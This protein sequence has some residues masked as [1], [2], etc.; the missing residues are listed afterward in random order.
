M[1][2][3]IFLVAFSALLGSMVTTVILLQAEKKENATSKVGIVKST[4]G[5]FMIVLGVKKEQAA[6]LCKML[7][8]TSIDYK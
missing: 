6:V 1:M 2:K 7:Q 8:G 3:T 4:E 5:D